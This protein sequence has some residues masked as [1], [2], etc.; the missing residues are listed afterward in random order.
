MIVLD[1][2]RPWTFI[3]T[4]QRWIKFLE[5]GIENIK[6]EGSSGTKDGWSK[7]K[8]VVEELKESSK[9]RYFFFKKKK[10]QCTCYLLFSVYSLLSP[11]LLAINLVLFHV[12]IS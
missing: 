9:Q 11:F 3:E 5:V 8:V 2:A 7:G 1:W 6:T 10:I 12:R 4:L